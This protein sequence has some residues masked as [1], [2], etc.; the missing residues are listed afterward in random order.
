MSL[1]CNAYSHGNI[2]SI[3]VNTGEVK[4]S[5]HYLTT[6][7]VHTC[8]VLAFS[9]NNINFLAHI[10]S[11]NPNMKNSILLQLKKINLNSVNE[12]HVWK[13]SNCLHDCPSFEILKDILQLIQGNKIVYHKEND[14]GVIFPLIDN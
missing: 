8:S 9:A 1:M 13:G 5:K 7:F 4:I 14:N 10:D 2:N 11:F 6:S 3:C 12:V